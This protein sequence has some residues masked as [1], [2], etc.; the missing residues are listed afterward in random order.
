MTMRSSSSLG[1][2]LDYAHTKWPGNVNRIMPKTTPVQSLQFEINLHFTVWC[3]PWGKGSTMQKYW[4]PKWLGLLLEYLNWIVQ[5]L[6]ARLGMRPKKL[7]SIHI[8]LKRLIEI[9]SET[10]RK[11]PDCVSHLFKFRAPCS[12]NQMCLEI[13]NTKLT[14]VRTKQLTMNLL[15][16]EYTDNY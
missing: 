2:G 14:K 3:P 8:Y 1:R 16:Y 11:I 7:G 9:E 4:F 13:Q 5:K 6:N 12:D 10:H 15:I